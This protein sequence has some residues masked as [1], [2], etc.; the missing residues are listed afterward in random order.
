VGEVGD[1]I[2]H[3]IDHARR[4]VA[5]RRDRD[6]RAQ[7][8][9]PIAVDVFENAPERPGGVD[10]H[11]VADPARHR[12][13]LAVDQLLRPWTGNGGGEVAALLKGAQ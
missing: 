13:G 7:I 10:G 8:D 11:R 5:D 1:L 4:R 3:G 12:G 9:K 2:L 6:T